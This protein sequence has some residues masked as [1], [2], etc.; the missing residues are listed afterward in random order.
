MMTPAD[1][2]IAAAKRDAHYAKFEQQAKETLAAL[3][4]DFV[5]SFQRQAGLRLRLQR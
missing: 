1:Q 2:G 5:Q 4:T 3:T